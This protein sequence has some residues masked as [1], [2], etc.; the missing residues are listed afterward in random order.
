MPCHLLAVTTTIRSACHA[1][2]SRDSPFGCR[3]RTR[4]AHQ[5][6]PS[7]GAHATRHQWSSP[8]RDG[9]RHGLAAHRDL[10][11]SRARRAAG[12]TETHSPATSA[13]AAMRHAGIAEH[14]LAASSTANADPVGFQNEHRWLTCGFAG[15]EG[16]HLAGSRVRDSTEMLYLMFVRLVGWMM[17]L[18]RSAARRTP[19]C[20]CSARSSR[21]CGGRT[22][23]SIPRRLTPPAAITH[24]N[25]E[26][27]APVP[28]G[29][30]S[31]PACREGS[32]TPGAGAQYSQKL[33]GR[34]CV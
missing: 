19:S 9:N 32:R 24:S 12:N 22:L 10:T 28:A 11:C 7:D 26:Q 20:W 23:A 29:P 16:L 17:L 6:A 34:A 15:G 3:T 13:H 8:A 1:S 21:S 33:K 5:P 2:S 14:S 18:V 27:Q 30:A 31:F 25:H 4:P